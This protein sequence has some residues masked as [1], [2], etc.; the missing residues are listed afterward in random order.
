MRAAPLGLRPT[1]GFRAAL[2]GRDRRTNGEAPAARAVDLTPPLA[3]P[4]RGGVTVPPPSASGLV[5][6][7]R[8]AGS[9]LA[10][11][12]EVDADSGPPG[13]PPGG[14][15]RWRWRWRCRF[16][17]PPPLAR[18]AVRRAG[19]LAVLSVRSVT[20]C[21]AVLPP[22]AIRPGRLSRQ[23]RPAP[24]RVHPG[25]VP[26]GEQL[27]LRPGTHH[28]DQL[29]KRLRLDRVGRRRPGPAARAGCYGPAARSAGHGC[30]PGSA[31]SAPAASRPC[32]GIVWPR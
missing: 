8:A 26:P 31:R 3:G 13:A 9:L 7:A 18:A 22:V 2:R 1:P 6:P 5:G 15:F 21:L 25:R 12:H 32:R 17:G 4:E 11:A 10:S 20:Q 30:R 29:K 23:L 27:H 24:S 14:L 16:L 28:L 19:R